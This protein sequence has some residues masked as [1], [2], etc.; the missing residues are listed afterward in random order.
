[1]EDIITADDTVQV[2]LDDEVKT[3]VTEE[4][5]KVEETIIPKTKEPVWNPRRKR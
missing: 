2:A 4:K 5:E 3:V 1:M